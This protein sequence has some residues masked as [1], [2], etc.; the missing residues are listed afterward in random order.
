MEGA[1]SGQRPGLEKRANMTAGLSDVHCQGLSLAQVRLER[2]VFGD[3]LVADSC[4]TAHLM[5]SSSAR[6]SRSTMHGGCWL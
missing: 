6:V 3:L 4:G 2:R 5:S 1:A